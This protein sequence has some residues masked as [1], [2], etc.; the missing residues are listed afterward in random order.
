V[1]DRTAK[2]LLGYAYAYGWAGVPQSDEE[3]MRWFVRRG[4]FGAAATDASHPGAV[5]ALAVANAYATGSEGVNPDVQKRRRWLRIAADA[6]SE[7][8]AAELARGL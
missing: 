1:G 2:E 4:L 5:E 8:A 7:K 3:A 6:G